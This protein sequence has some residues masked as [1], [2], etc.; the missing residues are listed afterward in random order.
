MTLPRAERADELLDAAVHD[1][2]ELEQSLQHVAQVNRWLGGVR[3]I[4]AVLDEVLRPGDAVLDVG[5]GGAALPRAIA[6]WSRRRNVQIRIHATDV[7]PQM[8][9]LAREGCREFPEIVVETADALRLKFPSG[10]FAAAL[11][12]LS[13][14]H[15][16]RKEQLRVLRELARV[17][18]RAVLVS[19]LERC[20]PNYLGA[21][22]MAATWW[23]RNRITRHDGPL[24]VL[25][26]FTRDELHGVA[27]KAGLEDV[28]V[29]RRFFYR[30][31]LVGKPPRKNLG[32]PQ[33]SP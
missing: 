24:S 1:R 16:E 3:P 22:L 11:M 33:R 15:F 26:A 19:E 21:R 28:R 32:R 23:R 14:H 25:R 13:L 9:Q 8:L 12:T 27:V 5:T 18:Q 31:L 30:L 10:S 29:E 20:W 6:L 2:A 17:A 7:H 4:L